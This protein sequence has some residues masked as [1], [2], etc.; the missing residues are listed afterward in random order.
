MEM[1]R[2]LTHKL[3]IL[4][5]TAR[6]DAVNSVAVVRFRCYID[7]QIICILDPYKDSA[8]LV[9]RMNVFSDKTSC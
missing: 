2:I 6:Y 5:Y 3:M 4:A 1:E 8:A 7:S 9:S